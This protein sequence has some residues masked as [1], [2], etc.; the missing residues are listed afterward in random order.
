M[1]LY[2]KSISVLIVTLFI[3]GVLVGMVDNNYE[4]EQPILDEVEVVKP[5]VSPGHNV[6]LQ[7]ISSD[8]CYYCYTSG[9]GSES[10]D[11]L[12]QS[13]PDE[14]V[15]ITYQSA[16]FS[17][18]NDARSGNVAPIF[19]MNHLGESGGAPTGYLGDSD[20]ARGGCYGN[21]CNG[22]AFDPVFE[23]GGYM[24]PTINDYQITVTQS[25]NAANSANVDITIE[26]AYIGSG[27]A[28]STTVLYAAVTEEKCAY[29]YNDGSYGHNCW[30]AWLLNGN[31]YATQSGIVGGGTGFATM[32]LNAGP[33]TET[34]TVPASLARAR[35]GQA[36]FDNMLSIGA[37]FSGWS[38]TSH[39]EDVF[40]VSDSSMGPKMELAV[41]DV[42]V[43]NP[44]SADG[45]I[46]G[47]QVTVT[48]TAGNVGGLN[49][50][51]GGNLE[52]IYMDGNNPVVVSSKPLPALSIQS[53][54]SHTATVDTTNLPANAW[55]TAFG[56]RLTNLVGD[57]TA[58]N[59]IL[60][61]NYNHDRPP[62]AKQA[63]VSGDNVIQRGS[64]F[65]VVAKGGANDYVDTIQTMSFELEVSPANT[66][67]WDGSIDS[68]GTVIVNEGT[69][70]EG[71]E[72]TMT[73]TLT[74]P[75]GMYDLRSKTID[76][77]GQSSDWRVTPNAF[78][79]ANGI[80]QVTAEPVPTVVCDVV[81]DVDMTP[82][83][84]DPETPLGNLIIDSDSPYFVSWNP[85]TASITVDFS[86][87]PNQGCPLG[88]KSI[89]V[90]VDDGG[91]YSSS[92]GLPY[93]TL[94][95]N[96]IEN[97]QPRWLGL[98][99]QA[100]DEE[101]SNS[102]STLRLQPYVTDTTPDGQPSSANLLTFDIVG[103]SNPGI[104]SSQIINGV[105]GFET[106]GS[107]SSGQTTLTLRACDEDLECSDQT[108]L[109]N[110]NPINDEP[111]IDTASLGDLRLKVG[112]ESIIDLDSLVSDVDNTNDELT[113]IVTSP[114]EA[115]GAQYNRQTGMLKLKFNEIGLKNVNLKVVDAYSSSE[116]TIVI[117]AYDSDLFTISKTQSESSFMVVDATNLYIGM[118]PYVNFY[119]T[120]AA[121]LFTS[122]E[123]TWQTCS[124]EGVCDGAWIYDLDM[125]QSAQGWET[126]MN[127][128]FV[129][130]PT[131]QTMARGNGYNYGDY[132]LVK[133]EGVD[134]LNNNY[135]TP[136]SEAP[137]W[138][139]TQNLP[140]ASEMADDM[141]ASH[142]ENLNNKIEQLEEQIASSQD[143]DNSA[144]EQK[145]VDTMFEL[146]LACMDSRAVCVTEET[147][148][149]VIDSTNTG[150]NTVVIAGVV[151]AIIIVA[152]LGGMFLMRGRGYEEVKG[153]QW[154]DTTLPARDAV[155]N[156][157]YGGTQQIFQQP[158]QTSY[159]TNQHQ[160]V[161]SNQYT[162]PA[163]PQNIPQ[164]VAHRGPPLPPGGLPAG[165]SMAQWEYYGQ[166]YLDRQ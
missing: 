10:A 27:S 97:G 1:K 7:Y 39:N 41:T 61:E 154:A 106:I 3:G 117:E 59:N 88:Q 127:I 108:V 26:A 91:D 69:N 80:P 159:Y 145:L 160:P 60:V 53:T 125:T 92:G 107:D 109:I 144:L 102:Y 74:M 129:G 130:D 156:S 133:M 98:P 131:G 21:P 114:S 162:Q 151:I 38:T 140:P 93:G 15:Y 68:G 152:L 66:N 2:D 12:K 138:T 112:E 136:M 22:Q 9:G 149:T 54:T 44:Q 99:T 24:A 83:I 105:L 150:A 123:V 120:D 111:V 124:G 20:P 65:T 101:G 64:I 158:I 77:R 40:A 52:I 128:P 28:P 137:K 73:P 78:S 57:R 62:T 76:S 43:D 23:Q 135:K 121:P 36:G 29:T 32:N 19:A 96:V 33:H 30:R 110:I 90:T 5:A 71:R 141:L 122:I 46:R 89:L 37:I 70:N 95:F 119:L 85:L 94:K 79:L 118:I 34:W 13:N 42:T 47:D 35:A 14:F 113:V 50:N 51:D 148:G 16:S 155:A 6:F 45:Y 103:E 58:S 143:E 63:T 87:N 104:I 142:I 163:P 72:Y 81:S 25:I 100:I 146:E 31:S 164:P 75:S 157:M 166:Q 165:W 147:S 153:F 115:G 132:F 4:I 139:I 126:E 82:H 56:A 17:V 49:Y 48:A 86:F 134:S 8:N 67:A 84:S 18:T 55:T 161:Y 11:N 116:Y